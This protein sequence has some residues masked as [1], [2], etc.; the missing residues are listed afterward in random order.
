MVFAV[1]RIDFYSHGRAGR[2]RPYN[3]RID[4]IANGAAATYDISLTNAKTVRR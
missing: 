2:S 1:E 3:V 4:N